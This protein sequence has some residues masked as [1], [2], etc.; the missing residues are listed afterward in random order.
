MDSGG[1]ASDDLDAGLII[2]TIL[3]LTVNGNLNFSLDHHM[4]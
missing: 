3:M 1:M 4:L 2:A